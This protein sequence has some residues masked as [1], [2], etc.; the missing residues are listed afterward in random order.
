MAKGR[1]LPDCRVVAL[2][3]VVTEEPRDM[4]RIRRTV[5]VCRMALV[6]IREL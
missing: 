3:A 2:R 1:R 6:A 4:V 5:E